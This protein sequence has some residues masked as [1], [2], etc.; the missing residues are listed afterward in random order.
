MTAATLHQ[1]AGGR[2]V[3]GLGA[4]TSALV[5]GFHDTAFEYPAAK[6][7]D[8][9]SKVRALLAGEPAH[10][11]A[12][13]GAHPLRLG[14][15]PAPDLPIWLAAMGDHTLRVAAELAD[16][17]FPALMARDRLGGRATRLDRLREAAG[18]AQPLT[19]AAGPLT[20][21]DDDPGT[22]R[23]IAASCTAWYV[24]AMGDVYARSLTEQG[25]GDA[26]EAVL[27]ANPRPSPRHGVVPAEAQ[28]VLDQLAT[29]GTPAQVR[30]RLETWG[31]CG[32]RRDAGA[33]PGPALAT[34]RGH[35]PSGGPVTRLPPARQERTEASSSARA[36]RNRPTSVTTPVAWAE[37]R[38][39]SLVTVEGLMST[40]TSGTEAGSR[41]PVAI[42][43]SMDATIRA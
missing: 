38:S 4:S 7:R 22:A 34:H 20:V 10:L 42:E 9:V 5:E 14:Q 12:V 36:P 26:V 8:V 28:P 11:D 35:P 18:R 25:Y 23:G 43:W 30:D 6:L 40:H 29:Y 32:R 15:P 21:V 41:L 1:I 19:V 39:A 27:A 24:C 33:A 13:P 37:P 17:W 3:L 16:G 31:R 2:Y